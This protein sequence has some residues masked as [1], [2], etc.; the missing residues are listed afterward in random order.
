[1]KIKSWHISVGWIV[2][3]SL[4]AAWILFREVHPWSKAFY[5]WY[6]VPWVGFMSYW[7]GHRD[8]KQSYKMNVTALD[9][10]EKEARANQIKELEICH[11][12]TLFT[13]K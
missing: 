7:F 9:L 12:R 4:T 3:V 5:Y 13:F 8:G 6:D 2:F 11:V 1:M 10:L